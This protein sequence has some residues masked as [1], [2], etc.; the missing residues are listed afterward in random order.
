MTSDCGAINDVYKNHKWVPAGW[1]HAVDEAETTALC[2]AA[3]NDLECGGVYRSNAMAAVRRGLLSED[4]ID[5]ALVRMFTAR[6]ET[7]AR[8]S[9]FTLSL[10]SRDSSRW[11]LRNATS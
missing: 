2:I 7:G 3:G 10:T 8:R 11:S 4:E 1:D 5:V 6:M 9:L